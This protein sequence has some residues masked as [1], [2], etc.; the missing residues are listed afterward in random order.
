MASGL[1]V[2]IKAVLQKHSDNFIR[3]QYRQF[4]H[5]LHLKRFQMFWSHL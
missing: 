5:T 2:K 1:V 3:R 4:R